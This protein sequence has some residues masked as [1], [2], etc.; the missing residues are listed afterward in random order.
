MV[1]P[2]LFGARHVSTEGFIMHIAALALVGALG[3]AASAVSVSAAPSV[4]DL[5]TPASLE[6]CPGG[7]R[8]RPGV[9]SQP[10]GSLRAK[11]LR[12]PWTSPVL[13]RAYRWHSPSDNVAN[14][15]NRRELSR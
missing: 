6:H 9:P 2:P 10:L 15:L 3:F 5:D 4:A 1:W 14:Q 7:G 12:L 13:E 8:L 11:S